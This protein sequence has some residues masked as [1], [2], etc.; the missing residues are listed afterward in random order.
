MTA[1][2]DT[3]LT[4]EVNAQVGG[5]IAQLGARLIDATAK[6]MADA[7]LRPVHRARDASP[8]RHRRARRP[9]CRETPIAATHH[10]RRRNLPEPACAQ[11]VRPGP[12]RDIRPAAL[13][14][15][16]AA[17]SIC[18]ILVPAV[19]KPACSGRLPASRRRNRRAARR[20]GLHR[21]PGAGDHGASGAVDAA[22]RCS[23]RASPAPARPRSPRCSPPASA[24]G[25]CGCNATTA[26]T[27]PPPPTSGITPAS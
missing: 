13:S 22:G 15:G 4:Y 17:S 23:W 14:P 9:P 21:R 7:V 27:S 20:P 24:A 12:V 8:S 16:S 5:K 3:L 2:D 18:G 6:Q 19:R 25:W 26:W 11:P 10:H 1:P